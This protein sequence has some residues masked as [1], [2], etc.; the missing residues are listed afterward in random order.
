MAHFLLSPYHRTSQGINYNITQIHHWSSSV[1]SH[2]PL[3]RV[4]LPGASSRN[5]LH[6]FAISLV[7]TYPVSASDHSLGTL[8][9]TLK[10]KMYHKAVL[11]I[12]RLEL[13]T[14]LVEW[15]DHKGDSIVEVAVANLA[16]S[17]RDA[18]YYEAFLD[19]PYA[20]HVSGNGVSTTV[21]GK[22]RRLMPGDDARVDIGLD[23]EPRLSDMA[24][25]VKVQLYDASSHLVME[26]EE[27]EL[28]VLP[29]SYEATKES[30]DTHETP[31]W[32]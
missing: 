30:L 4:H 11:G 14:R 31:R 9:V 27:W 21:P 2:S 22:I 15:G 32:V 19:A 8:D 17:T 3:K 24:Y 7:P 23:M 6:I 18:A 20:V 26:S 25:R 16:A 12:K 13:T 28:R 1:N 5:R 29:E 10:E